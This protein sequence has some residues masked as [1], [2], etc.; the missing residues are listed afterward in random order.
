MFNRQ[1]VD[2]YLSWQPRPIPFRHSARSRYRGFRYKAVS[3]EGGSTLATTT[4]HKT[5]HSH[6][7]QNGT[8]SLITQFAFLDGIVLDPC[9]GRM[10][11]H[12]ID[13]NISISILG[14]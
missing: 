1:R 4:K 9:H 14:L 5:I 2:S 3:I 11:P 10:L 7:D 13:V 12:E 6:D 8:A